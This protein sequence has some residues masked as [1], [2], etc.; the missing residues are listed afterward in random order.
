MLTRK[1]SKNLICIQRCAFSTQINEIDYKN[2]KPFKEIP[3]VKSPFAGKRL[4]NLTEN[5]HMKSFLKKIAALKMMPGGRFHNKPLNEMMSI[6][7]EDYGKL[8]IFNGQIGQK[9]FVMSFDPKDY[10]LIFRLEGKW[11]FRRGLDSFE[12]FRKKYRPDLFPSGA[13]LAI[14]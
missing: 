8:C 7:Q 14:E 9:P 3:G 6:M 13:G 1:L 12:Y 11:P 4:K 2:A 10:E 5:I